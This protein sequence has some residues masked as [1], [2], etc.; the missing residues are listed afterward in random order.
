MI[1]ANPPG[2]EEI[3][4]IAKLRTTIDISCDTC[5]TRKYIKLGIPNLKENES[6][7]PRD[8]LYFVSCEN[9][10]TSSCVRIDS[11]LNGLKYI[12]LKYGNVSTQEY[13]Q[14]RYLD[15]KFKLVDI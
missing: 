8:I 15:K 3:K 9:C 7:V 5:D 2:K 11:F 1:R 6:I 10:K 13:K 14:C 4:R 12:G